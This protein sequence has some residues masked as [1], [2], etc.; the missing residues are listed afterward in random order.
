M[1]LPEILYVRELLKTGEADQLSLPVVLQLVL[2]QALPGLGALLPRHL[3]LALTLL[4]PVGVTLLG[5]SE[6]LRVRLEVGGKLWLEGLERP[7]FLP[8]KFPLPL[9]KPVLPVPPGLLEDL[10]QVLLERLRLVLVSHHG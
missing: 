6:T 3:H 9:V 8:G 7:R 10:E 2:R 4:R 1:S 5:V